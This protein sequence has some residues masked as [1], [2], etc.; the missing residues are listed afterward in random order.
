VAPG[1]HPSTTPTWDHGEPRKKGQAPGLVAWNCCEAAPVS[2][3]STL[4]ER[5]AAAARSAQ[6]MR[7]GIRGVSARPLKAIRAGDHKS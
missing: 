5:A 4:K 3:A 7:A 2:V 6:A 1:H